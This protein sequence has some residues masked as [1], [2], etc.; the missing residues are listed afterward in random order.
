MICGRGGH[1]VDATR[2][3]FAPAPFCSTPGWARALLPPTSYVPTPGSYTDARRAS[4]TRVS[5]MVALTTPRITPEK[6]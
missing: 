1:M 3:P 4:I 2:V 5:P 6:P